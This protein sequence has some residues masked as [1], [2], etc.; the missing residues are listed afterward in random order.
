MKQAGRVPWWGL[1]AGAVLLAFLGLA[2]FAAPSASS[3]ANDFMRALKAGDVDKLVDLSYVPSEDIPK[4]RKQWEFCL[5]VATPYYNFAWRPSYSR[6]I[7]DT[8]F[9]VRMKVIKNSE[10]PTS[11]D[12]DFDIPLIKSGGKWKVDVYR[13]SDKFYPAL[14]REGLDVG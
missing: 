1:V 13:L 10:K 4:I 2:F 12:E 7:S 3:A 9:V 14:P 11:Y 5:H 6:E 8:E